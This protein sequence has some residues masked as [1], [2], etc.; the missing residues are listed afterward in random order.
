M[1]LLIE[2]EEIES[3]GSFFFEK[4]GLRL[5]ELSYSRAGDDLV[6][7]DHTEVSQ[8]RVLSAAMGQSDDLFSSEVTNVIDQV[9]SGSGLRGGAR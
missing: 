7:L 5:A 3:R 2:H 6:I 1:D 4:E 9:V 8:E